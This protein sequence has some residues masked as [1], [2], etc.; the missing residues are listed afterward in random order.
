MHSGDENVSAGAIIKL[1]KNILDFDSLIAGSEARDA[2]K[3]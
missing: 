1:K 2:R 3:P